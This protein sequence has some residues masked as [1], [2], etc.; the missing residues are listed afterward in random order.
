M[1]KVKIGGGEIS[2]APL[3]FESFG[4]RGMATLVETDDVSILIDPGS[5]L[6]PRFNFLPHEKEYIALAESRERILKAAV[7]ADLVAVS[8]YHFDH[9]VPGFEEWKWICSSPELAERIY[10]GKKMLVKDIRSTINVSQRKRGFMFQKFVSTVARGLEP[11][12]GKEF[13]F[14]ETTVRFSPP[15]FHGPRGSQLGHVLMVS[16][17]YGTT[18]FVHGSDVQGPVDRNAL[19]FILGEK[20][21]MV[22]IGGPPLYLKGFRIGDQ[23][24]KAARENMISLVRSIPILVIDHHLLRDRGYMQYL[25][26]VIGEASACGHKISTA[27]EL[28]G[29]KPLLLEAMRRELYEEEP[30]K[31]G[32]PARAK[33]LVDRFS[34]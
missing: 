15:A 32:T 10:R 1:K 2:V 6:G 14:G 17:K 28:V 21:D 31:S 23:E 29:E 27:S 25:K 19:P 26:P 7:D 11:A 4:V 20:P 12:D 9:Y 30:M 33:E 34:T 16:V 22:V 5:A 18:S 13:R 3:A 24:L 8:H